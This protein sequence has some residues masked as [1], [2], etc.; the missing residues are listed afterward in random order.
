MKC[1]VI[2][3][4]LGGLSFFSGLGWAH[5]SPAFVVGIGGGS[6]SGKTTLS[7]QIQKRLNEKSYQNVCYLSQDFYYI[8]KEKF[9]T[10]LTLTE[11]EWLRGQTNFDHPSG[12]EHS[13]LSS[14]LFKLKNGESASVPQYDFV[15]TTRLSK[16]QKMGPCDWIIVEGLHIL[17]HG[18][19]RD[20]LDFKIFVQLGSDGRLSRRI[21]RDQAERT[22]N[23]AGITDYFNYVVS[24]EHTE[25]VEPSKDYADQIVSG[26][27]KDDEID[28]LVA[29]IEERASRK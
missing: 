3:F 17:H 2:S 15:S 22:G 25:F 19:I 10:A 7:T 9:P 12:I 20:L 13:L 27:F 1:Y 14:Q 11:P 4:F 5:S 16:V 8:T 28:A 6:A 18:A 21:Q 24:P 29:E 26:S 23:Q